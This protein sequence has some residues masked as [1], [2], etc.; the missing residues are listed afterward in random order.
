MLHWEED[1]KTLC[2]D[3]CTVLFPCD[4]VHICPMKMCLSNI[5]R[6]SIWYK[7]NKTLLNGLKYVLQ[8]SLL[9]IPKR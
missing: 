3:S 5:P 2:E 1:V 9:Y 4:N 6:K 8:I 7:I